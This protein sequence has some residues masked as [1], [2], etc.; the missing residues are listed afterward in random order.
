MKT[1]I[2]QDVDELWE[3]CVSLME[4]DK[5]TLDRLFATIEHNSANKVPEIDTLRYLSQQLYNFLHKS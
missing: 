3:T 4:G 5:E 1:F 2:D